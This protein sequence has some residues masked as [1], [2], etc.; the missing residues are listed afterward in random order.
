MWVL[1]YAEW[2]VL[3]N[4]ESPTRTARRVKANTLSRA[5]L[6]NRLLKH[7]EA[8]PDFLAYCDELQHGPLEQARAKF[9]RRMPE[10]I[11]AHHEALGM[12]RDAG[13]HKALAQIA[14]AALDRV[15]PKRDT[16][17]AATQVQIILSPKQAAALTS[18]AA[19]EV[20]DAEIIAPIESFDNS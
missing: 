5:R 20:L 12:A 9:R 1:A 8:R 3:D 16:A 14:E 13:D 15:L 18:G 4:I 2:L 11:D 19:E 10:Y 17:V 6:N 7:I